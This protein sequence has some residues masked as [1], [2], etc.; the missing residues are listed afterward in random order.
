M[1][2]FRS[3]ICALFRS[4]ILKGRGDAFAGYHENQPINPFGQYN[5]IA[6]P[7]KIKN[8]PKD[9]PFAK[10]HMSLKCVTHMD[11]NEGIWHVIDARGQTVGPFCIR[12]ARLL[13]GKHKVNYRRA[14]QLSGDNVIIVNAIHVKFS[15][16]RWDTKVYRFNRK[17][18][19]G[20]PKV[21]TAKTMMSRNPAMVINICVKG[22]LN[23]LK[24]RSVYLRRLEVYSGAIHP[25]WGIP[26]VIVPRPPVIPPPFEVCTIQTPDEIA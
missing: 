9:D 25:H 1:S 6:R 16:H 26:Q 4:R 24:C 15:G 19:P 5:W 10:P 22:S 14:Y 17:G 13:M 7:F 12:I 18:I 20:G 11:T 8:M 21:I 3:R 2:I 23:R